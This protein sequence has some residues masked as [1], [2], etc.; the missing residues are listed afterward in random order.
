MTTDPTTPIGKVR[1]LIADTDPA[2]FSFEDA[3]VQA[4][5]DMEDGNLRLAAATAVVSITTDRA[6]L[7]KVVQLGRYQTQLQA[8]SDLLRIA[9]QL[10]EDAISQGGLQT[11]ELDLSDENYE[12]FRPTW[13]AITDR[14]VVE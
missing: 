1:L 6:K 12:S 14:P 3:E 5:L 4:F 10:R 9:E 8:V 13:R 11:A 7:A 2:N